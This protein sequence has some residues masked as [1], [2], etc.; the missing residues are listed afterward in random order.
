MQ[1]L[2][3]QVKDEIKKC[4]TAL[5]IITSDL[6]WILQPLDISINKVFKEGLR[7][8]YVGY[9]IGKNNIKYQRVQS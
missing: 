9:W 8:K 3:S 4:K 1:L 2:I 7:S 6:T 5:S